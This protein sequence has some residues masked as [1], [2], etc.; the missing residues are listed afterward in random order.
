MSKLIEL[1][2]A[3]ITWRRREKDVARAVLAAN[4]PGHIRALKE[5]EEKALHAL[6]LLVD[7]EPWAAI[8]RDE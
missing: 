4:H 3:L 5:E 2:E 1:Q 8:A 6:R 7:S